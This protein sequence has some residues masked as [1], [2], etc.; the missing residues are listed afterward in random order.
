MGGLC[1]PCEVTME[2]RSRL[3]ASRFA[4]RPCGG[5]A[6]PANVNI[7]PK[8]NAGLAGVGRRSPALSRVLRPDGLPPLCAGPDG[9]APSTL[10]S[11]PEEVQGAKGAKR[12][13]GGSS[14]L[15]GGAE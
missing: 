1:G 8:P 6:R 15:L 4:E 5:A 7:A 9:G 2:W 3:T 10:S 14:E 13:G 12:S 11:A